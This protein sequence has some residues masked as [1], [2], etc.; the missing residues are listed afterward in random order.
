MK[1][2]VLVSALIVLFGAFASAQSFSFWNAAGTTLYCNWEIFSSNSS[3][4]GSGYDNLTTFCSCPFNSPIIGFS[5]SVSAG[6]PPAHGKGIVYGDGIYDAFYETYSGLQWSVFSLLTPSKFNKLGKPVGPYGWVS[7]A[8]SYGG[9]YFGDNYGY[10][11]A[12]A[13]NPALVSSVTTTDL[14]CK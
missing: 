10:L 12:G 5:S 7:V 13:P 6:G 3:G 14:S 8:G 9:S 11:A 1:K 2:L 4:V